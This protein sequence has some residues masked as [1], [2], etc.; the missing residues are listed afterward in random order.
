MVAVDPKTW[1]VLDWIQLEQN[2]ASRPVAETYHGK[3]YAYFSGTSILYRYVWNGK[4]LT[5]DKSWGPVQLSLLG[6]TGIS[7]PVIGGDWV[8]AM[9]NNVPANVSMSLVAVSQLNSSK[10]VRINPIPLKAGQQ[11]FIPSNAPIDPENNMVYAMDAGA[12][13]LVGIKYDPKSG[14]MS[15]AWTANESTLSWW[16][17]IGPVNKRV[18]LAS[19]IHP[20]ATLSQMMNN[21]PPAY[22]E[23]VQ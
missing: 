14:N 9:N 10:V 11:S 1:K 6:Q 16:S 21:P 7:A 17:V 8:F 22:T 19:N 4:N 20:G 12:G 3:S 15:L 18:V 13:K 23:Q 5:L 2:A